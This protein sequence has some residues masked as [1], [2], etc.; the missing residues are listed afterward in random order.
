[1]N[2]FPITAKQSAYLSR[3]IART[4]K[5][6]YLNVKNE[7]NFHGLTTTQLTR[8]QASRLIE[9]LLQARQKK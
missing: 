8:N 9:A 5:Q 4:E 6:K 1:M 7:L 2:N 3:L